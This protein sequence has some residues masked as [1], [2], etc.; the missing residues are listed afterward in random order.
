[1]LFRSGSLYTD[2]WVERAIERLRR[3]NW[4]EE[5]DGALWFRST[6]FGD[7]KDRVIRKSTGAFTYFGS[8]IGYV[9]EKFSRGFDHL[10]YVWGADHHGTVAR[11]RNA[12]EAMGYEKERVEMLLVAWVRFVRDGEEMSMSKRAG[13]F[14]TLDELLEEIGVDSARWFF[15]S[16]SASTAID[17]DIELA[18][19]QNSENPVYYAQYAHARMRSILRKA[20]AEGIAPASAIGD[21]LDDETSPDA[22]LARRIVRLPEAVEDAAQHHETQGITTFATELA[23]AFS[24]F[25]RDAK[26]VDASDAVRSAKR[27]RLVA[28]AATSLAASLQLLGIS[29]PE[30]M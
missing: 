21:L 28:A 11:V 1:M 13:T 17:F 14:I 16:R 2:G 30:E 12:A 25:Y 4:L 15:A 7:D 9:E 26:V 19:A 10:I 6:A 29:A 5:R 3:G 23:T 18:K 24:A 22:R 20:A 27:L 8:D